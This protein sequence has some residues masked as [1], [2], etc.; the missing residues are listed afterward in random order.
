M[1]EIEKEEWWEKKRKNREN[2]K[3]SLLETPI[4]AAAGLATIDLA[5][6]RGWRMAGARGV[7]GERDRLIE[8]KKTERRSPNPMLRSKKTI[9]RQPWTADFWTLTAI[10]A[11][12][13]RDLPRLENAMH[14]QLSSA[15][16][17]LCSTPPW[18]RHYRAR[19]TTTVWACLSNQALGT[20][21]GP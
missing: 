13:A 2:S 6:A 16:P 17:P 5:A 15:W 19:L 18:S 1:E 14:R 12:T 11:K 3:V 20:C 8:R 9:P 10:V 4:T 21:F 7:R